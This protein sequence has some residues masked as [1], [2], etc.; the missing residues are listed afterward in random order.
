MKSACCNLCHSGQASLLFT[1]ESV[2]IVK[3]LNCGLIYAHPQPSEEHL[4]AVYKEGY[5][6]GSCHSDYLMEKKLYLNRFQQRLKEI[7]SFKTKGR[8]LDV[9]CAVG[10]FLETVRQ[11]GWEV[12]GVEVSD[13]A[14]G[15][16]RKAGIEVFTGKLEEAEYPDQ[17]FD[18][19]TLWHVL[20][21][22]KDPSGCLRETHRVLNNDG[23][24]AVEVPNMDSKKSKKAGKEWNQIKP[25]EHLFYF[26]P[27]VLKRM[28]EKAGFRVVKISALPKGTDIGDK[29]DH[30]GLGRVK[31]WL[32]K[33]FPF[34]PWIKKTLLSLK[35]MA[36][37]DDIILLYALKM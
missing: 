35:R 3:C 25:Q 23:L 2:N 9:G 13:F 1:K 29:L 4:D 15:Y 37:E 12:S 27:D 19:V 11:A 10:Y 33:L 30:M 24:L 7:N 16:A 26:T 6:N 21:H 14:A 28:V 17:R 8:L 22:V 31:K 5:F 32:I 34:A 20:E 18:V 36:G